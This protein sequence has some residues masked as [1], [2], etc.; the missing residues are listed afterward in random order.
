MNSPLVNRAQVVRIVMMLAVAAVLVWR[1]GNDRHRA[2][3]HETER[4]SAGISSG[5]GE[6]ERA[7]ALGPEAGS[8]PLTAIAGSFTDQDGHARSLSSFRGVPFMVSA[9]Y[10][11]CPSVCPR[12]VAGLQRIERSFP[13]GDAPRIVLFSLD[14]VHDTPQAL[15]AFAA[16]HGLRGPRWMLLQPDTSALPRLARVLGLAYGTGEGGGI[17]HTAVIAIVDTT[18]RVVASA[19]GLDIEPGGMIAAWRTIGMAQRLPAD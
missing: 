2:E 12:T 16:A 14:P 8:E 5:G 19:R 6:E 10:T 17:A 11:R 1:V 9:I 4:G 13:V 15:R 7:A 18:G 3:Q